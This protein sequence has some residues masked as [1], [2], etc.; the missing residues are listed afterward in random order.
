MANKPP[1]PDD[2]DRVAALDME[3]DRDTP[4]V[5]DAMTVT[6]RVR[7]I[8]PSD[9]SRPG[10]APEYMCWSD[11]PEAEA[12]AVLREEAIAFVKGTVLHVI[13]DW[14]MVPSRIELVLVDEEPS[15]L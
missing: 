9:G 10:I 3:L 11:F 5:G 2:T 4:V 15:G 7:R 6:L 1:D 12:A 8:P 14:P 13:A